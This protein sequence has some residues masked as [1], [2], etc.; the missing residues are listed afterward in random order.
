MIHG[1]KVI[2]FSH[3][4]KKSQKNNPSNMRG[5][6]AYQPDLSQTNFNHNPEQGEQ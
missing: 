5:F 4:A 2:H 1:A 3:G 6:M